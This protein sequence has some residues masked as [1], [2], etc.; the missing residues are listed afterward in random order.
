MKCIQTQCFNNVV[1]KSDSY[2]HAA[3]VATSSC[4]E[5]SVPAC[6]PPPLSLQQLQ[7]GVPVAP[8]ARE[9]GLPAALE[10][11][12]ALVGAVLVLGEHA[13]RGLLVQ[14]LGLEHVRP[15]LD[16]LGH[17]KA[18]QDAR[19]DIVERREVLRRH[20]QEPAGLLRD[21][22]G[23]A[24]VATNLVRIFHPRSKPAV[25]KVSVLRMLRDHIHHNVLALSLRAASGH[26]AVV[27]LLD[28]HGSLAGHQFIE[29]VLCLALP[30]DVGPSGRE[31]EVEELGHSAQLRRGQVAEH[32]VR[33]S[34]R[35]QKTHVGAH[36]GLLPRRERHQFGTEHD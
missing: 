13:A 24:A 9:P 33:A 31:D 5:D 35:P 22:R 21:D 28:D 36:A 4:S 34:V 18:S 2:H 10:K 32:G 23:V 25:S 3:P 17:A 1:I 20:L 26:L 16:L 30:H 29:G 15:L 14:L 8:G 27:E 11:L 7:P 19:H 6:R 12:V